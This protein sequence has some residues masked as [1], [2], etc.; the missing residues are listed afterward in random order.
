VSG[1]GRSREVVLLGQGRFPAARD[2]RLASW[3]G[4]LLG[5]L[6]PAHDSF[7]VRLV[8]D[9]AMR[10]FNRDYRGVDKTTDVLSFSGAGGA[11]ARHLGDV[12]ISVPQAVRQAAEAGHS[13]ARELRQLVLH[14]MLHCLGYD[15][16][17][18]DGEMRRLERR[19]RRRWLGAP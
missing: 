10:A 19:L 14:G 16:E 2:P 7:A 3:I 9:R 18:D 1:A 5:A 15:H 17:R 11:D 8:G 4:E 13:V 6:A 12:V